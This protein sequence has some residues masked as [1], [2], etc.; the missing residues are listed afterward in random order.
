MRYSNCPHTI[1]KKYRLTNIK[2]QNALIG[3]TRVKSK[4]IRRI[5]FKN[6]KTTT[7]LFLVFF[8]INM[9]HMAHSV[10]LFTWQTTHLSTRINLD[11]ETADEY[12]YKTH[13]SIALI[14]SY[15]A[16]LS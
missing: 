4:F 1:I 9:T 7:T 2:L 13:I 8:S 6:T 5:R 16:Y 3:H 11:E 14:S 12:V 10:G 15:F